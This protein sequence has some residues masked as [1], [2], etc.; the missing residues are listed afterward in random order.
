MILRMSILFC[1]RAYMCRAWRKLTGK[2]REFWSGAKYG[3]I[4]H[5]KGIFSRSKY[6]II[7]LP[8]LIAKTA[9]IRLIFERLIFAL[10]ESGRG[11]LVI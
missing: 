9:K 10:P 3:F 5:F 4:S 1:I 6:Q 7:Y 8:I 2:Y 11:V